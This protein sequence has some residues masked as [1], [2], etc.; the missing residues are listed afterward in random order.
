MATRLRLPCLAACVVA[1]QSGCLI[2]LPQFGA[3]TVQWVTR[4]R[5]SADDTTPMGFKETFF[6]QY[7]DRFVIQGHGT[8][9]REHETWIYWHLL[10]ST[11][12]PWPD[13]WRHIRITCFASEE[14]ESPQ[15]C[16]VQMLL[17]EGWPEPTF[18]AVLEAYQGEARLQFRFTPRTVSTEL[19]D[20]ELTRVGKPEDILWISGDVVGRRRHEPSDFLDL[21]VQEFDKQWDEATR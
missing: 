3:D 13:Y 18:P 17:E 12:H 6:R 5:A 11:A 4:A 7:T 20:V 16:L 15:I 21:S 2:P 14:T 10:F 19:L 8:F 9:P 1:C